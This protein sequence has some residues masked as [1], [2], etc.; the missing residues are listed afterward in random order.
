MTSGASPL[1]CLFARG[2]R[3]LKK[4]GGR[5]EKKENVYVSRLHPPRP[6]IK[7]VSER[8][9]EDAASRKHRPGG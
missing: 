4:S 6:E 7:T 8:S 5:K 3:G 1:G 9:I 2:G